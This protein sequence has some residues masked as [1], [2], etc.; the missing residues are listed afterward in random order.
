MIIDMLQSYGEVFKCQ[1][2]YKIFGKYSNFN[3]SGDRVA[4]VKLDKHI[5]Q[6]LMI[7]NTQTNIYVNYPNQ[8]MSCHKCG[9]SAHRAW[10]CKKDQS[11][12]I[13]IVNLVTNVDPVHKVDSIS[14]ISEIEIDTNNN[15]DDVEIHIEASQNT[16]RYECEEC[17]FICSYIDIFNVHKETHTGENPIA[18]CECDTQSTSQAHTGEGPNQC[19][20]CVGKSNNKQSLEHHILPHTDEKSD[21]CTEWEYKCKECDYLCK[22]EDV[23]I[24]HLKSHNIYVCNKC[25]FEGKTQQALASHLKIH[26][27]KS[28]KCSNCDYVCTTLSKLNA[29]KKDH[30]TEDIIV[31]TLSEK[32]NNAKNTPSNAKANKRDLS[33]SPESTETDRKTVKKTKSK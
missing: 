33:I 13:N 30:A 9:H 4:W 18:C 15:N 10:R 11:S 20:K 25:A 26:K 17:G 8:P 6:S 16:R 24:N 14:N 12:Y 1:N 27:Q 5:P 2:Y 28:F 3:S 19:D 21:D 32:I 23:L 29:H 31:E 22:N 7:K